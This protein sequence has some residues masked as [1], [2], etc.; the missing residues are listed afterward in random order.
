VTHLRI[1]YA[2]TPQ[3][4]VPALE[5][6][7]GAGH[8]LVA[9]YSQPDR[10]AGRGRHLTMS[11]VKQCAL[12]HDLK[13][14]QPPTL[15]DALA[16]ER[17]QACAADVMIVAAYGLLLPPLVLATP[18][19][20]CINIHASLLPRWRGAAPIQ[21]AILAGD[22]TTGITIMRMEAGLDTGPMLLERSLGIEPDETAAS[23]HDRLAVLGA[24][25]LLEALP[26]IAAGS[27]PSRPQ[28]EHGV[29]HAA[30]IRKEEAAIHWS[31]PAHQI[32][33]QV[34]AFNP[35]PV[36]E[37]TWDGRQLRLWN[38]RAI[39]AP[40][41]GHPGLVLAS[42]EQGLSVATGAGVL[43]VS[44]LQSAGGKVLAAADFS[45]A[46]RIVGATLGVAK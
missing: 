26:G 40:C 9:V 32:A 27:L 7:L 6:L 1:V 17:L 10:P 16:V 43:L 11:A 8:E 15:R 45:N 3:F 35:W 22:T 34:R 33:R 46:H 36:A 23:L 41:A 20:G 4:A 31:T 13:V 14:E 29:T 12:Q 28:P 19:L 2:G 37:T 25:A 38:A 18:P 21:R 24:Q 44:R 39:D 30:K 5:A 42:D